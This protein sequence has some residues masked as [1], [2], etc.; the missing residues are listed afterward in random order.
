MEYHAALWSYK[1]YRPTLPCGHTGW[2]SDFSGADGYCDECD[3]ENTKKKIDAEMAVEKELEETDAA[4]VEKLLA[5]D[6]T[7]ASLKKALNAWLRDDEGAERKPS[8]ANAFWRL[9][10]RAATC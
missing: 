9:L 3:R 2:R 10:R 1:V 7:S 4:L 5:G 6:V 8:R